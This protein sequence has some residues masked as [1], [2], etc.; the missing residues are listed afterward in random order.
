MCFRRKDDILRLDIP[1]DHGRVERM[2]LLQSFAERTGDSGGRF[3]RKYT[4]P[5]NVLGQRHA[6]DIFPDEIFMRSVFTEK[7]GARESDA[8]KHPKQ[9]VFG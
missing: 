9:A 5:F 4:V 1:V 3:F 6:L 7:G 2:Q 8:G